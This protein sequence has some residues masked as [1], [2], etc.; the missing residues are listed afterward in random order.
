[1]GQIL[2]EVALISAAVWPGS[3]SPAPFGLAETPHILLRHD[4]TK[5]RQ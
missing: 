1:M 2:R 5:R 3:M 4:R